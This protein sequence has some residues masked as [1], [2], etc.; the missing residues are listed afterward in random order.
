MPEFS[1][2]YRLTAYTAWANAVVLGNAKRLSAADLEATRA[3]LFESIA[4][5]FDHILVVAEMFLAHLEGRS[6]PHRSRRRSTALA[7]PEVVRGIHETDRRYVDMSR[8]WSRDDLDETVEF[9]FVDGGKGVM[10]RE[11]ILLHLTNHAT[12]HRGFVST[13]L[14]PLVG[15]SEAS[16]FTVFL[17]DEWR[18]HVAVIGE[19]RQ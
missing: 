1:T 10:S 11:D 15:D 4:G 13:L 5:T 19:S 16:D 7:F 18:S 6:N 17:R 8:R 12:Y 9:T 14:Y 3:T 2:A